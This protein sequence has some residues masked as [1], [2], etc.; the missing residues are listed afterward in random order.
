MLHRGERRNRTTSSGPSSARR[1][2]KRALPEKV[3]LHG[4]Q[5]ALQ[6]GTP[7]QLVLEHPGI[8]PQNR[9]TQPLFRQVETLLQ[10]LRTQITR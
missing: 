3:Q 8:R 7:L 2:D 5:P 6:P 1:H 10:T 4:E 9:Q